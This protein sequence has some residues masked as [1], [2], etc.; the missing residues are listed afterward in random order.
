MAI[1]VNPYTGGIDTGF[2][3]RKAL[4]AAKK[5]KLVENLKN[6]LNTGKTFVNNFQPK[7]SKIVGPYNE[8]SLE[9]KSKF[10]KLTKEEDDEMVFKGYEDLQK[11]GKASDARGAMFNPKIL[12]SDGKSVRE[13]L[14]LSDK[15][16]AYYIKY[17]KKMNGER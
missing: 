12:H 10:T 2:T 4:E 3:N 15:E 11:R 5:K 17:K 1:G 6:A 16:T 9:E 14:P 7:S 8:D 13:Y